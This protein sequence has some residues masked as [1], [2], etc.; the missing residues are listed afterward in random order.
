LQQSI[1]AI[2]EKWKGRI[3]NGNQEE[4][5]EGE[6][7]LNSLQQANRGTRKASPKFLSGLLVGFGV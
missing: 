3:V 6:E 7:A 5:K 4:S 1:V 2:H